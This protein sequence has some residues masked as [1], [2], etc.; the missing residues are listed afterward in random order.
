MATESLRYHD[1]RSGKSPEL[2]SIRLQSYRDP[3]SWGM[4]GSAPWGL[5]MMDYLHAVYPRE[6]RHEIFCLVVDS[7]GEYRLM[8]LEV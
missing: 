5:V 8:T 4:W 2:Y 6:L 7:V 3:Q 1:E